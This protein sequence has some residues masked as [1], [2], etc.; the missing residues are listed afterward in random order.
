MGLLHEHQNS[1]LKNFWS[2]YRPLFSIYKRN[3]QHEY[4]LHYIIV[5]RLCRAPSS[6]SSPMMLISTKDICLLNYCFFVTS[7]LQLDVQ[8]SGNKCK[9]KS[10]PILCRS[11][12]ERGWKII[13]F[14]A[15][16]HGYGW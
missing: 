16:Q 9:F 14:R 6:L 12:S 4:P 7:Q 1:F 2:L 3:S 8:R 15:Y 11:S 10:S 13:I 5:R